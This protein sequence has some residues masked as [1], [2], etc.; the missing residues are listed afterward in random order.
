MMSLA[1][2]TDAE[3]MGANLEVFEFRLAPNEGER[4]EGLALP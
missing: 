3:H 4:I 1:G 2:T